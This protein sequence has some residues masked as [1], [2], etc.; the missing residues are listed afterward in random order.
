MSRVFVALETT[1]GRRIVVKVL[2]TEMSA[3]V[4]DE[5]FRREILLAASLM[6]PH[7]IPVLSAGD[8]DGLPYYTMPFVEGES[9][10]L[11][12]ARERHL[13]V[14]L[15]LRLAR[16]I[17]LGLDYAHRRGVVH[18]DIK[19]ENILLHDGHALIADFGIAR[20]ISRAAG[21]SALTGIGV[22]LGTPAYMSPEQALGEQELD[23][24]SDV[25]ALGCVLFEMLTGQPPFTGTSAQG[26]IMRHIT[27]PAPRPSTLRSGIS[28][29]LDKIVERML[30]KQPSDRYANAADVQRALAQCSVG[31]STAASCTPARPAPPVPPPSPDR[32]V[33]VLPFDN[34]SGNP[35]NEYFSDGITEDI[36]AQLSKIRGLKVMSRTSA[37]RY[38]QAEGGVREIARDLGV[39]HVLTGSVRWAG[40]RLRIAAQ[41]LDARE[42]ELLWVETF[43]RE[44]TDVFAVQSE[45]AERI[46]R[47]LQTQVSSGEQT[48]LA[49]KPTDD[50]EAY[51]LYLLGRHHQSKVT[52]ADFV[53][54]VEYFKRAIDRDPNFA[55]A[56]GSL[57]EVLFYLGC[58]YWGVRP[59]DTF[60]EG[61]RLADRALEL[62]PQLAEAHAAQ[63]MFHEWYRY[64]YAAAEVSMK[65]A[66]ALNPSGAMIH[67]Y[68]G[69][70]LA[71]VGR[72]DEAVAERDAACE[73]DPSSMAIRGNASWILYLTRRM[74]E[75]LSEGRSIRELEPLS[76]YAAFSHGLICVQSDHVAEGVSA[77]RD[78]VRLSDRATLYLLSLAYGLAVAGE[79]AEARTLLAECHARS[80]TEFVWPM[81]FG[82]AYA[83][84]GETETAIDH[85][86]RAYEERVGWMAEIRREPAFD[87][88]R[89][90]PRFRKLE[91]T[92]HP[93][94]TM[95]R[96]IQR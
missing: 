59:H 39:T 45:V 11:R 83:H 77:F 70:H 6:H 33:V 81:G 1:L 69:M 90:H 49:K 21:S 71:A 47:V 9:L 7:I 42:D 13:P 41:L 28:V 18:R 65:T 19:P 87:I 5:R 31:S 91:E 60:P 12:L 38:K 27:D 51:N 95:P 93:S 37:T 67:L 36:I 46:A 73:L 22:S 92:I 20:A 52:A 17:A 35:E 24:R 68:Y 50:L 88:L 40:T 66:V 3:G 57:A 75:A 84:L 74:P 86:E 61:S 26:V 54:A 29:E 8:A 44:M 94:I 55:K 30:A 64:D 4:S 10:R 58:G 34:M 82:I 96:T 78:A 72:F 85:L 80:A 2:P 62:D 89:A 16:E 56:H 14:A 15:S 79:H 76:P 43:D 48:R 25:Y 63:G 32:F 53:K 23:G